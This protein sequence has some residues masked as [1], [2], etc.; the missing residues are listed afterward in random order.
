TLPTLEKRLI[1]SLSFQLSH[2]ATR[3]YQNQET[4]VTTEDAHRL[5]QAAKELLALNP[6]WRYLYLEDLL[7][8]FAQPFTDFWF[9]TSFENEKRQTYL[10]A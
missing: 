4:Y 1:E 9:E 6:E 7:A 2:L 8:L 10:N 3:F 5:E